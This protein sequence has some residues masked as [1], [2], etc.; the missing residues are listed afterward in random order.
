M[1]GIIQAWIESLPEDTHEQYLNQEK[2]GR[3]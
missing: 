1:Y 2:N 3:I